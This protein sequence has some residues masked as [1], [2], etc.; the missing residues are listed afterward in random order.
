[1]C[2]SSNAKMPSPEMLM[3]LKMQQFYDCFGKQ[4]SRNKAFHLLKNKLFVEI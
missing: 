3:L 4:V 1:M 2:D